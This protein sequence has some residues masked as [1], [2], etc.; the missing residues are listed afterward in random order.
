[1]TLQTR[2]IS[3]ETEP[4]PSKPTA[5]G[6]KFHHKAGSFAEHIIVWFMFAC[7]ILSI[8]ITVGIVGVLI[9]ETISFFREV[10]FAQ[11]FLDTRWTPLFSSKHF[12]I[13]PLIAGTLL[14]TSIAIAV[15]LPFGLLSAIYL[16]EFAASNVRRAVKP[17]LEILAGIPTI[18]Y[19]YFALI[20]V[21]PFLQKI[22]PDLSGFNALSAGLVMGVMIIPMISS[23]SEDA[24]YAV[25]ES[26]KEGAYALGSHKLPS[27][28]QVVLPTARSGIAAAT[29]LAISRAIGETMI[30]TIAAGQQAKLTFD[31]RVPIETMTAYIVQISLGETP[32]GTLEF[33]T[34]FVVGFS[35]FCMTLIM[36]ILGQKLAKR[37]IG[38]TE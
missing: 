17:L 27:I 21:T 6:R 30:V 4:D 8:F 15:A 9:F 24:I 19:G 13:W 20:L 10:T 1:M 12:G 22:I 25:P 29:T 5:G 16:S 18:V 7:S 31:P 38:T 37:H 11:F 26:L 2:N 33:K 3:G 35:L 32:A 36:N 34:I 23:L 28:F 14:T